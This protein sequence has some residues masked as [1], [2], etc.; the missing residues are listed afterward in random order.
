MTKHIKWKPTVLYWTMAA[1]LAASSLFF[2]KNLIRTLLAEQV[3]APDFILAAT[4]LVVDRFY[5]HGRDQ[6]DRW[7]SP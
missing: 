2:G 4:Q 7:R 6:P 3:N 1:G 5:L